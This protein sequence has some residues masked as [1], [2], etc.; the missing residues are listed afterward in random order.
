MLFCQVQH[1]AKRLGQPKSD[2]GS[3]VSR[4]HLFNR[5]ASAWGMATLVGISRADV[6][7]FDSILFE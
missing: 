3:P 5:L 1:L 7:F 2:G 6:R 4:I